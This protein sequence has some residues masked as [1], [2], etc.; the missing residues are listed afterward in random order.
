MNL[1]DKYK[2]LLKLCEDVNYD[3]YDLLD[4]N[5]FRHYDTASSVLI[6]PFKSSD[7]DVL[8]DEV[9]CRKI[10][11]T[12]REHINTIIENDKRITRIKE[13]FKKNSKTHDSQFCM[14]LQKTLNCFKNKCFF[15]LEGRYDPRGDFSKRYVLCDQ[16]G[17]EV[18]SFCNYYLH[19]GYIDKTEEME[20]VNPD[21]IEEIIQ[22]ILKMN[23]EALEGIYK[24]L[25]KTRRGALLDMLCGV[26]EG[27]ELNEI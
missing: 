20:Q 14:A 6:R 19:R 7:K 15:G 1:N 22:R 17:G 27:T 11:K 23:T 3:R 9:L 5:I 4:I 10:V 13:F 16:C 8:Y 24:E 25:Q 18:C 26:E 21:N 2:A 12:I